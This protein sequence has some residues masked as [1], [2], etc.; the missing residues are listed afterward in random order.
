MSD[1]REWVV[2]LGMLCSHCSV[3]FY[4][5]TAK[6]FEASKIR[7]SFKKVQESEVKG[8]EQ[9]ISMVVSQVQRTYNVS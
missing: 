5:S 4:R 9:S 7:M 8:K 1:G 3:V 2:G 6:A